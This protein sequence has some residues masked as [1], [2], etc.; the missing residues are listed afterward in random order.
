MEINKIALANSL[1]VVMAMVYMT[2]YAMA[3]ASPVFFALVFN[4]QFLGAAVAGLVPMVSL[5]TIAVNVLLVAI[6]GWI[7]GFVWGSLYNMM[8]RG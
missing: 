2:F 1:A 6:T 7:I 5:E 4:A 3:W 8:N